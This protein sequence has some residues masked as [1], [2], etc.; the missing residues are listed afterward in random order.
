LGKGTVLLGADW[1]FATDPLAMVRIVLV[2]EE[3][4]IYVTSEAGKH[5][6][7][8]EDTPDLF[9]QIPNA[10]THQITADSSRP[11]LISY[12]RRQGFNVV[13]S[14]KGKGSIVE[15]IAFLQNYT[16]VIHPDCPNTL[17]EVQ[18]ARY[19]ID[20]I[21]YKTLPELVDVN[22]HYIDA[23]RYALEEH[24]REARK[25]GSAVGQAS[26]VDGSAHG[27]VH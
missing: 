11:E 9:R 20:K 3:R 21:T 5:Q 17:A 8:I 16:L 7:E 19:K 26:L 13:P 24:I 12:M 10:T 23:I 15:G 27:Q 6:C 2:E 25:N 1:G 14:K 4:R 18:M 22:N